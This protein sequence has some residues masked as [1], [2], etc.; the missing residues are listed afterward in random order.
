MQNNL[1]TA[2]QTS[3]SRRVS[4]A[5]LTHFVRIVFFLSLYDHVEMEETRKREFLS[6]PL[7]K[8]KKIPTNVEIPQNFE[9]ISEGNVRSRFR[10]NSARGTVI[11]TGGSEALT[12]RQTTVL[13]AT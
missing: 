5:C 2:F 13:T 4:L 10:L 3:S 1:I 12:K 6:Q 11:G 9:V 8:G 7:P